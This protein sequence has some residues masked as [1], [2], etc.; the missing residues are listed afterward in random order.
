V[1]SLFGKL[2]MTRFKSHAK[3]EDCVDCD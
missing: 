1:D 2:G 3:Y